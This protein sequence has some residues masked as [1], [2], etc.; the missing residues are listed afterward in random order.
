[1]SKRTYQ[2]SRIRRKR[3]HGFRKRMLTK[4]GRQVINRRRSRGRR[5]LAV[6]TPKK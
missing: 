4:K 6:T 3:T 2:P 5:Q 1:M